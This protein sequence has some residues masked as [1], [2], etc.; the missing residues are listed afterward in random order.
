[1]ALTQST[2]LIPGKLFQ[3][4]AAALHEDPELVP[5][6]PGKEWAKAK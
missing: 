2:P 4:A 5:N 1:M 6:C 3:T